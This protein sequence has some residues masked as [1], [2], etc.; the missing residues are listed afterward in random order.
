MVTRSSTWF[1][2]ET[3]SAKYIKFFLSYVQESGVLPKAKHIGYLNSITFSGFIDYITNTFTGHIHAHFVVFL[4]CMFCLLCHW[5]YSPYSE[6]LGQ[7]LHVPGSEWKQ[8]RW[9]VT[10][11][12]GPGTFCPRISFKAY[13]DHIISPGGGWSLSQLPPG[14]RLEDP[15]EVAG[16]HFII[17][18]DIPNITWDR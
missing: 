12:H 1:F 14:K 5:P 13:F 10:R 3:G 18:D 15:G 6:I 7:R 11:S 9:R 16:L 4:S 2:T 8:N 17:W